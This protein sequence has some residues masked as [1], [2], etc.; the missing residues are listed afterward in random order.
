M[1][2][3]VSQLAV[4]F[5]DE[6][7]VNTGEKKRL[8]VLHIEN[9]FFLTHFLFPHDLL[10]QTLI[11]VRVASEDSSPDSEKGPRISVRLLILCT[12]NNQTGFFNI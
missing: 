2:S 3:T 5:D 4:T 9:G 10:V 1:F 7:S 6:L 12:S 8:C 11:N